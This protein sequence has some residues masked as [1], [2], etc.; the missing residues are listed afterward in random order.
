MKIG[1][2]IHKV[3]TNTCIF[4]ALFGGLGP[5]FEPFLM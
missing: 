2:L 5:K 1:Q 3:E 4:F